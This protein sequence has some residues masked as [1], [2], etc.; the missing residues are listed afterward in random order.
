M[1]KVESDQLSVLALNAWKLFSISHFFLSR[2]EWD[3]LSRS[4]KSGPARPTRPDTL[5]SVM[6]VNL[7]KGQESGH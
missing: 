4:A 3:E 6:M 2:V 5:D 7:E 1:M